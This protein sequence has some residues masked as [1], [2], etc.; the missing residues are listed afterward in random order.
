M[1]AS[2]INNDNI[3]QSLEIVSSDKDIHSLSSV[4]REKVGDL[5]LNMCF[6]FQSN[7]CN[8]ISKCV[9]GYCMIIPA[10]A[11]KQMGT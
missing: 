2:Q 3:H 4:V 5:L 11:L 9:M 10:G 8:N 7:N 1:C 6:T